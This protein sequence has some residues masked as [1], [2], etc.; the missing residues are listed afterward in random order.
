VTTVSRAAA[1]SARSADP[2]GEH[3]FA[4]LT[5]GDV[6]AVPDEVVARLRGARRVLTVCHR[7][8]EADAL[9]S[10][11]AVALLVEEMGGR[12]T[13]V[14]ADPVPAMYDFM[15]RI[16]RFAQAPD[17]DIDYDLIVVGDCGELERVGQVLIDHAELFARVPILDID[18]HKSNAGFGAVDWIDPIAS[19]TCEMVTLLAARLG[20]PLD[21]A[22]GA[23]ASALLAGVVIDTAN[24]QHPN[25]TPRTLRVASELRAAG[26]PLP[27]IARRLYRSKPNAQLQLFGRV[28]ARLESA[29][30]GRIVWSTLEPTD[31]SA[32]GAAP[33]HSE[34]LIDLL[35]QSETG[36]VAILFKDQGPRTRI[37][38][39]TRDGGVDAT[40]LTGE[41]GGGGHARAA[42]ATLE[43]PVGD[44]RPL[45]IEQ[46]VRLVRALPL[47]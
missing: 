18:H 10:A 38:V 24:F 8:P 47:R 26:A 22:G 27:D 28:L 25:T 11:L 32:A 4:A 40:I 6:A 34:G 23:L 7:D 16:D 9:G 12:A 20:I 43:L 1:Q 31:I 36:E 30:A 17:P 37:S 29:E 19:A 44:A 41:Y 13:P 2:S 15:P 5:A 14:C 39:R 33:E 45:V 3:P 35:A 21:S 42:G 46:A